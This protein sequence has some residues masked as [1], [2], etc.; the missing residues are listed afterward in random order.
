M[1]AGVSNMVF[2]AQSNQWKLDFFV[3]LALKAK[4]YCFQFAFGLFALG[5]NP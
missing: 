1:K 2:Y 5:N 4:V 3:C